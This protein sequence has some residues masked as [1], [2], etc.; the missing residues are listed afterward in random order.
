M[1]TLNAVKNT[2]KSNLAV[3]ASGGKANLPRGAYSQIA[4]RVRPK[5]TPNHVREVYLGRRPSKRIEAAIERFARQLGEDA[6]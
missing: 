4:R 3:P 2:V 1:P 5:V 6:A